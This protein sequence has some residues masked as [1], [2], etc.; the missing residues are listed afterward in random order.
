MDQ[1]LRQ[2]SNLVAQLVP[3][4]RTMQQAYELGF[5]C[6]KNGANETNCHFSIFARPEYTKAWEL[7]K[8]DAAAGFSYN[9]EVND[10]SNFVSR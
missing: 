7:G 10:E 4:G 3:T 2:I 8:A 1:Q 9:E 6:G 5:D